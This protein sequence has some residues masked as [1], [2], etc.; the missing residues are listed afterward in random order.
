MILANSYDDFNLK[1]EKAK[2]GILSYDENV[3]YK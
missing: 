3:I 2:R 1:M